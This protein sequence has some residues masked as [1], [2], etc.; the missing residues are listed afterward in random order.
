MSEQPLQTPDTPSPPQH[1]QQGSW[2]KIFSIVVV[3]CAVSTL[4]AVTAVYFYLFPGPFK[5]V[6][7]SS[8]EEQV[9]EQKLERLDSIQRT[10]SLHK[11]R[12][13]PDRNKNLQPERYTETDASREVTLTERELNALLARNTDLAAK[14]AIDLSE[15][16]ASARLRLPLDEDL[17]FFGGKILKVSA[18]LEMSYRGQR[19]VVVLRGVSLWGVPIPNAWLGNMK[20]V[21]LVQEFGDHEGFWKSFADGIDEVKISDGQVRVRLRE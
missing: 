12:L 8:S 21:D 4:V 18:G 16:L 13:Q 6:S 17:P 2:L 1:S 5:P 11:D 20:N 10:P 15:D 19:P 14:L 9:L 7:L 3:A